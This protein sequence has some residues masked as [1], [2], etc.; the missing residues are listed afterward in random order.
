[1]CA[2]DS[3]TQ[4]A[5]SSKLNRG[6][7]SNQPQHAGNHKQSVSSSSRRYQLCVGTQDLRSITGATQLLQDNI[8]IAAQPVPCST[9][10]GFGLG[11]RIL[12]EVRIVCGL[13]LIR[14]LQDTCSRM[15][16]SRD[17]QG[18]GSQPTRASQASHTFD[19]LRL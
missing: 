2:P 1:M 14:G 9:S 5:A 6:S 13:T 7:S 8:A 10:S 3:S 18:L 19:D 15:S 17:L 11:W 12:I 4:S 16:A